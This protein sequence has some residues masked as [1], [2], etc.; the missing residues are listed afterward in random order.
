MDTYP[1]F[2]ESLVKLEH[3]HQVFLPLTIF[4]IWEISIPS[5]PKVDVLPEDYEKA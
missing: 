5:L 4:H 2:T 1:A 3:P